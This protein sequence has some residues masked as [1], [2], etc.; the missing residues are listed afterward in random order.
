MFSIDA[1]VEIQNSEYCNY[2]SPLSTRYAS[3]EMQYNFS[4][5]KKFSTW[6]KLWIYLAKAE[7]LIDEFNEPEPFLPSMNLYN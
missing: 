4:D 5:Q 3:K 2:R 7:K 6:R 1:P